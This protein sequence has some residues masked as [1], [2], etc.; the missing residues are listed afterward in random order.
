MLGVNCSHMKVPLEVLLR[1]LAAVAVVS[2]AVRGERHYTD[3]VPLPQLESVRKG[4][5][6]L[7]LLGQA[8]ETVT[9]VAVAVAIWQA[10]EDRLAPDGFAEV[11]GELDT[12]LSQVALSRLGEAVKEAGLG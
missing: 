11:V 9:G 5:S 1:G 2:D 10:E 6:S 12:R 7:G 3:S 4:C 8:L